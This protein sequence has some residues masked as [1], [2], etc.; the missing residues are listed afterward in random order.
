MRCYYMGDFDVRYK[1]ESDHVEFW[2][3]STSGLRKVSARALKRKDGNLHFDWAAEASEKESGRDIAGR[4]L[5]DRR[6]ER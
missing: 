4:H 6:K 1:N 5:E 2:T 3:K